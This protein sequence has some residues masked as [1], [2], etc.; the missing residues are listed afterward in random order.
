[1]HLVLAEQVAHGEVVELDTYTADDTRLSPAEREL[2]LVIGLLFQ[3]PVNVD[4]AVLVVGFDVGVH[5]LWVEMSHR[6][7]LTC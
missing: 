4:G 2:Q 7:Q 3:F 5:L 1:M 6:G